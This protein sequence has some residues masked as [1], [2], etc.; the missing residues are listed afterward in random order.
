[1]E[2]IKTTTEIKELAWQVFLRNTGLRFKRELTA[3]EKKKISDV[4]NYDYYRE[5]AEKIWEKKQRVVLNKKYR[6]IDVPASGKRTRMGGAYCLCFVYSKYDGNFVLK[7]YVKEIEEYLKNNYTHYFCNLSLWYQGFNRD[8]WK[9]WKDDIGIF[10][11]SLRE[12]RRG[13]KIRVRPYSRW[14]EDD[15]TT[16]EKEKMSLWFKR[17]PKRWIPEFDKF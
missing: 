2:E 15:A 7:G 8:I 14:F 4:P 16:E 6:V 11:P 9:F 1:M 5:E 17:L 10:H 12:K 13:K 3:E